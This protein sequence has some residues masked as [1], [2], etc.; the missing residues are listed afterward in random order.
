MTFG[1]KFATDPTAAN[2]TDLARADGLGY[3]LG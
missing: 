3:A 1:D 2:G